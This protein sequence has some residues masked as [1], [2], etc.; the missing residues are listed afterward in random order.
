VTTPDQY[1][2]P[3]QPVATAVERP[4]ALFDGVNKVIGLRAGA[5]RLVGSNRVIDVWLYGD[6]PGALL[7]AT[8]WSLRPAP[9][10]PRPSVQSV[11]SV[12]AS[13][14]ADGTPI[15]SHLTLALDTVLPGR[16][17]YQLRLDPVALASLGVSID[18]LRVFLALR[19][20]PECGEV[21]DC[22][23]APAAPMKLTAPDYDTLARDYNA[24]RATLIERLKFEDPTADTSIADL[25]VTLIELFAHLGDLLHYRLDRTAT[26]IWLVSARRR[27]NVTRLA[28][29]VDF[30]V[31][32]AISAA[33]TVQVV[34]SHVGGQDPHADVEEGDVATDAGT[35]VTPTTTCFTLES[36]MRVYSSHAEIAMY[37]WTEDD[38]A[39]AV[40][41]TSAVLVRPPVSGGIGL[42]GW[43]PVGS[44][45]GFEVV[46]VDDLA[47]Q[48]QWAAGTL[49][50]AADV[51][52]REPLASRPA[53][54]VRVTSVV[55]FT[56]PLNPSVDLVRVFWNESDAL[57]A[58]VPCSV[59]VRGGT[60]VGVARLGLV[61]AHH[62]LLVDG[63]ATLAAVDRVTGLPADP[64][65]EQV[66]DYLMVAAGPEADPGLS[67]RPGGR[68][69]QLD[70]EVTLPN[71]S[72]VP[73]TRVTSLLRGPAG[74]FSVV[75]DA[76]DELP[77]RL[78][79]RTGVLGLTPPSGSVVN[80]RYQVGAGPDG[81]AAANTTNRLV[82][83]STAVGVPCI[84]IDV[85]DADSHDVRARNLT[86]GTGGLAAQSLD[87]VRR[88]APQAYSA[89]P[90]RAVLISDLP[91]FA[92]Q[93]P[94]VTRASANRSWSGSWPVGV[95]A[96]ETRETDE[97]ASGDPMAEAAVA[98]SVQSTL[99][100]VRM[101]G[102]EAVSVV[103][104]P[105]GILIAL[106]VCLYPGSDPETSRVAILAALRPGT[107]DAP[108][109]FAPG[110]HPMGSSVYLSTVIATV[111]ALPQV[112][113]VSV[114]EARRLSNPAG[115]LDV[116][117]AMDPSEVAVCD[118]DNNYPD[119]GR[120][121]LSIEG[122]R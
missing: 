109:L 60:C 80:A 19:L 33:T 87:D 57:T 34:V 114:T 40:G 31:Q 92:V 52:P 64:A 89:Q 17:A 78:R 68:P 25:N 7:D 1:T 37:D 32:P 8:L 106:T 63:P 83:T 113:A 117:L 23:D 27:A 16:G 77:A 22:V 75:V 50:T 2:L 21:G 5:C 35:A 93:V 10:A 108:G 30:P 121:V 69:W 88:D 47:K 110:A 38:A 100:A 65:S 71:G 119:R 49:E 116:V 105:V 20:R 24:L 107:P 15:P 59:E 86:P 112:D 51:W 3:E 96:Y 101:C 95:A 44:L 90:R 36:A 74:G 94:T 13:V 76:D 62:G 11:A 29:A 79:F 85:T 45:M 98:S 42:A 91:S 102:T 73:A 43:L 97:G 48:A 46:A 72:I 66:S 118:D 99:D 53:Q 41:A 82:R 58:A 104:S 18:P 56:D 28:R 39:L 54:V 111:A 61:S 115:T 122:G 81:N 12:A 4:K 67:H 9:G 70:V 55:P 84:W 26:E 6:P 120:I 14:D 103:A